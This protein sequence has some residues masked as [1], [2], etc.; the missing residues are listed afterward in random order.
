MTYATAESPVLDSFNAF[1]GIDHDTQQR[2][3]MEEGYRVLGY[4]HVARKDASG[5]S[6]EYVWAQRHQ[7]SVYGLPAAVVDRARAAIAAESHAREAY[8]A[9][10]QQASADIG[11]MGLTGTAADYHRQITRGEAWAQWQQTQKPTR[12]ALRDLGQLAERATA[13]R[14]IRNAAP[15]RKQAVEQ[16]AKAALDKIDAE[17]QAAELEAM[18]LGIS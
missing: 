12:L 10:D 4:T 2:G 15:G 5:L 18:Q 14:A 1:A 13:I 8:L 11:R 17:L 16:Q 7:E 6:L 9:K 3:W